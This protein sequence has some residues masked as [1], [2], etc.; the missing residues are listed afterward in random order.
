MA[1][2]QRHALSRVAA[3]QHI[4]SADFVAQEQRAIHFV[5]DL[6]AAAFEHAVEPQT[7]YAA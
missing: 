5:Y 6:P 4:R 1:V 2:E 7:V 3:G